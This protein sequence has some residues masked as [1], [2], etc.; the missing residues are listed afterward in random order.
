M[1]GKPR[2]PGGR[3][4]RGGSCHLAVTIFLIRNTVPMA[5]HAP[6]IQYCVAFEDRS[7]TEAIGML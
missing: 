1:M 2:G 4:K 7:N 3:G 5:S 6:A